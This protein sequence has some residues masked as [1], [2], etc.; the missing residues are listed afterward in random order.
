MCLSKTAKCRAQESVCIVRQLLEYL[1]K[2]QKYINL[3]VTLLITGIVFEDC[4]DICLVQSGRVPVSNASL[5]QT[6]NRLNVN[7]FF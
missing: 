4:S 6:A 1:R 2:K 7:P 3:V 5:I